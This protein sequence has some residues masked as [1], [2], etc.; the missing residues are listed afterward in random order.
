MSNENFI[1]YFRRYNLR[2][3]SLRFNG[4]LKK[5]LMFLKETDIHA[6]S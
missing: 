6:V 4:L 5:I 1:K 3:K 2:K